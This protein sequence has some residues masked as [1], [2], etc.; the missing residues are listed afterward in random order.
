MLPF[1]R[2]NSALRSTAKIGAFKIPE[3][4]ILVPACC[5]LESRVLNSVYCSRG[6]QGSP[7]WM[8]LRYYCISPRGFDICQWPTVAPFIDY[9]S[10][11]K[12]KIDIK[13]VKTMPAEFTPG[14]QLFM[15]AL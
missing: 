12:V 3:M 1:G 11:S 15:N 5:E 13:L 4:V 14:C 7:F 2:K 8:P 10:P 9:A 6:K